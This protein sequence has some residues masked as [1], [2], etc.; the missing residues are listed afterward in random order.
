MRFN[1]S[2]PNGFNLVS[3]AL[4]FVFNCFSD[5][6]ASFDFSCMESWCSIPVTRITFWFFLNFDFGLVDLCV[7][8]EMWCWWY[9]C[10]LVFSIPFGCGLLHVSWLCL[11]LSL[12]ILSLQLFLY[13]N[14]IQYIPL[15]VNHRYSKTH[16]WMKERD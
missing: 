1:R 13:S 6:V 11:T 8:V 5:L 12:T 10:S 16:N 9:W 3:L 7:R 4:E 14:Y 15:M 2:F